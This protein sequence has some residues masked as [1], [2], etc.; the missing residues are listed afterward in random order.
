MQACTMM[1]EKMESKIKKRGRP[2]WRSVFYVERKDNEIMSDKLATV[3][4]RQKKE[5]GGWSGNEIDQQK[6]SLMLVPQK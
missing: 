3:K 6:S 1:Y 2:G 5:W 4:V